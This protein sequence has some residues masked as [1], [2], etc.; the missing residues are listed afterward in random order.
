MHINGATR[1][2]ESESELIEQIK[3]L[4]LLAGHEII[5]ILR[6]DLEPES[7]EGGGEAL[8]VLC[9]LTLGV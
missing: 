6:G 2:L 3:R 9:L 5:G 1:F 7:L 8:V 4:A